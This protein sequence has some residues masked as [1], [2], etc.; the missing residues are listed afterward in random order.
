MPVFMAYNGGATAATVDTIQKAGDFPMAQP[1]ASRQ[2]GAW[3]PTG[4]GLL[5]AMDKCQGAV[6]VLVE[7]QDRDHGVSGGLGLHL[8]AAPLEIA[9]L[10]RCGPSLEMPAPRPA[11]EHG[12][13]RHL[14]HDPEWHHGVGEM[15]SNGD[16]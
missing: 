14:R 8:A 5:G 16:V 9:A 10:H 7:R 2:A 11:G 4:I 13:R 3:T 15:R 6:P 1:C 12:V